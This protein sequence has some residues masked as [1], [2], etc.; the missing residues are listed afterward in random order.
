MILKVANSF[1]KIIHLKI[2][3]K[4]HDQHYSRW[5]KNECNIYWIH[6]FSTRCLRNAYLVTL[7]RTLVNF[8]LC[9]CCSLRICSFQYLVDWEAQRFWKM[10]LN[11]ETFFEYIE[12]QPKVDMSGKYISGNKL[13]GKIE[14]QEVSFHYPT[15]PESQILKVKLFLFLLCHISV[16]LH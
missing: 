7:H 6:I 5:V 16:L 2:V 10:L 1:G 3:S 14:F 8:A 11:M 15:R 12:R 4:V 13:M 9:A